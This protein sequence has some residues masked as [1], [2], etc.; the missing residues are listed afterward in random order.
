MTIE[1]TEKRREGE[2]CS[3]FKADEAIWDS[4][5]EG[6]KTEERD[7]ECRYS[8]WDKRDF[9]TVLDTGRNA[10]HFYMGTQEQANLFLKS[11]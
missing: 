10:I 8:T 1:I 11:A 5:G 7:G 9:D 2:R 4:M 6:N 3:A